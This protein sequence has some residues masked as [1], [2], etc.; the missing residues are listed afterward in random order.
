MKNILNVYK[1]RSIKRGFF[2]GE[3]LEGEYLLFSYEHKNALFFFQFTQHYKNDLY[4]IV[5]AEAFESP[6]HDVMEEFYDNIEYAAD[7]DTL[8]KNIKV[9]VKDTS[10]GIKLTL[11]KP[12]KYLGKTI[13]IMNDS[14]L[15]RGRYMAKVKM[16]KGF[17]PAIAYKKGDLGFSKKMRAYSSARLPK[18]KGKAS[19]ISQI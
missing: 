10:G 11:A 19:S 8:E 17:E 2:G 12:S 15:G 18:V 16:K 9:T 5:L 1:W 7:I 14:R 6:D 13:D 4:V 3:K